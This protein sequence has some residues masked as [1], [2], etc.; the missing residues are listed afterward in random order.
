MDKENNKLDSEPDHK[1]DLVNLLRVAK[2]VQDKFRQTFW[3]ISIIRKKC[4]S[5]K[6]PNQWGL[7]PIT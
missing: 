1:R 2:W 6:L 4:L 7:I 5:T 3:N